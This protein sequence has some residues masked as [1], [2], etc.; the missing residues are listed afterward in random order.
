MMA[1][2]IDTDH[3]IASFPPATQ[4]LLQQ[5]RETIKA[6]APGAVDVISYSMPAVKL[7][8]KILA[9]FAGYERHIG[10]YP[11][12]SGIAAFQK[13]IA[14]Y[15]NAKG[16]V[17]FPLDQPMPVELITNIVKFKIAENLQKAEMKKKPRG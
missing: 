9:W 5:V 4:K 13:E 15:K 14:G 1:K 6:T 7:N 2:P 10:F 3:Y 8:G 17:Q 12:S 11:G 16:S